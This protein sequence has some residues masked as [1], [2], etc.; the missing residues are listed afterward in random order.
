MWFVV[1][2]FKPDR[3]EIRPYPNGLIPLRSCYLI[4]N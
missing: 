1:H 2:L 4:A 3:N